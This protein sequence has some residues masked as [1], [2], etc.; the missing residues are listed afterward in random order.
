[1]TT[2][3]TNNSDTNLHTTS[4]RVG[5]LRR[6]SGFK[7]TGRLH[8]GNYLGAIRPTLDAQATTDSVVMVA[9][10]HALTV[11][12]DPQRL[13]QLTTESLA[14]MLAAGADPDTTLCYV[15]SDVPEHAELHYLLECATGYGEAARMI[16][17]RQKSDGQDGV[18]LSLLTYPVLMAADV[19]LHDADEVPVGDDQSP[20]LELARDVANRFN[21][22]YGKTF[23][24]PRA[25]NPDVAARVMD[26]SDPMGKM[27]KSAASE[28]G[29]VY[30][31]DSP[32]VVRRKV[33]RAV[34]DAGDE[35]TYDPYRKPGVSNLLEILAAC[36]RDQPDVAALRFSSY[37][38]L[39]Q[40]VAQ[41]IVDVLG[42]V[43]ER[44]GQLLDHPGYLRSV[45]RDGA[46]RA[47]DRA[48][49]TVHR[50]KRAIGLM[51]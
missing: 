31:L 3:L 29:L 20:H 12:H 43:R 27:G 5:R 10:L 34:T 6:L 22:R 47:R 42:P 41:A 49:R 4:N 48:A 28:A 51:P 14:T 18:R 21:T 13:R 9:D 44:Y 11:E 35:V 33:S 39:K 38:E 32:D 25:V 24:V 45:R 30:L 40:A 26:L 46:Q 15:Q 36:E 7:P 19:L 50:A 8:L 17:F 37:A 23:V 2:A 16:Q 1:M